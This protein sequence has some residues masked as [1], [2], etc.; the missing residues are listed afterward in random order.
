MFKEHGLHVPVTAIS[1]GIDTSRFTPLNDGTYLKQR[2]HIP[3]KSIVLYTGRINEEKSL[4][5]L[6]RAIPIVLKR[7]DAH[8]VFVGSGGNY[9]QWLMALAKKLGVSRNTSFIDFLS[10]TDFPNIYSLADVFVMPS[11]AELQSIVTLE[12]LASGF[13]IVAVDKG[14][15]PE[16][17]TPGNG[18]LSP[19]KDSLQ[20]AHAIIKILTDDSLRCTMGRKSLEIVKHHTMDS[21]RAQY[22]KVYRIAVDQS[23]QQ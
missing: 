22:E 8:F 21:V 14:A 3:D 12:A 19:A 20:M 16:L 23:H 1:N 2:F 18:I 17:V 13:P 11:E 9:R 6:I 7:S 10:D 4:D 5:V 15:V